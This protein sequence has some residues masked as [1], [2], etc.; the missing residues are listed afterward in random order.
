MSESPEYP[1][2]YKPFVLWLALMLPVL[3]V[4][5]CVLAPRCSGEMLTRWMLLATGAYCNL[6]FAI[7]YRHEAVYWFSHGPEF[8]QARDA[9]SSRRRAYI[10]AHAKA[11]CIALAAYGVFFVLSALTHMPVWTD[12]LVFGASLIAATISTVRIRL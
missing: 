8:A 9:G 6:L 3:A 12:V 1:K 5:A 11:F 10:R 2:T 4:L 7:M